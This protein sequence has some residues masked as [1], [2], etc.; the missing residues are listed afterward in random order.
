M[1]AS[2]LPLKKRIRRL[3]G[4]WLAAHV[5]PPLLRLL[6]WSWRLER[7]HP[8][9]RVEAGPGGSRPIFA[10]WHESIP[11]AVTGHDGCRFSVMISRHHDGEL[12]SRVAE[13]FGFR[14]ARGSPKEGGATAVRQL[15]RIPPDWNPVITPDGPKGPAHEVAP[16]AVYLAGVTGRRLVAMG[17]AASRVWRAGSWDRMVLPKPFARV[18]VSYSEPMEV[19]RE[20]VRDPEIRLAQA[21]RL[22]ECLDG[23]HREAEAALEEL[24]GGEGR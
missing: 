10:L 13:R 15:L 7:L 24:Q 1:A 11:L 2:A 14:P 6:C 21:R 5:G 19:E 18:V 17:F 9:R 23:V 16:G 3:V 12:V 4:W 8:E 20:G 22:K